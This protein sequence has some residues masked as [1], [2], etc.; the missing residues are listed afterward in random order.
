MSKLPSSYA[1]SSTDLLFVSRPVNELFDQAL[2][3]E[4]L[5][6]DLLLQE[7]ADAPDVAVELE[8]A[9]LAGKNVLTEEDLRD[10]LIERQGI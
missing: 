1:L 10:L 8:D 9:A 7:Y 6:E 2:K 5:F 3:T 4:Y